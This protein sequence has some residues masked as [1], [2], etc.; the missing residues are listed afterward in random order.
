MEG[1][2]RMNLVTRDFFWDDFFND[3][4]PAKNHNLKCDIYE[5]NNKYH[6]EMDLPGFKKEDIHISF[7]DKYLT[8]A[9]NCEEVKED[10]DKNYIRKERHVDS[11]S[12]SFYVGNINEKDVKA[13]FKHGILHLEFPKESEVEHK[14]QIMIE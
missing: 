9:A 3:M 14:K 1:G 5:K 8:I 7:E 12:R 2:I 11:Y 6:I 13:E 10:K 4:L